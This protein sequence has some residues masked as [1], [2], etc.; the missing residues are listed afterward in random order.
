MSDQAMKKG[1][2]LVGDRKKLDAGGR[3]LSFSKELASGIGQKDA[4]KLCKGCREKH[5]RQREQ[6]CKDPEAET[7]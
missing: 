4:E 1:K 5:S 3:V 7:S 6:K 2:G